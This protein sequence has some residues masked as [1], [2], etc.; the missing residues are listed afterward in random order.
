MIL[1]DISQFSDRKK[2]NEGTLDMQKRLSWLRDNCTAECP[3][4]GVRSKLCF[5]H[6]EP[7]LALCRDEKCHQPFELFTVPIYDQNGVRI[8]D[9]YVWP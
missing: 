5:R 4:C 2:D 6:T 1:H 7:I 9:S 8:T 3:H